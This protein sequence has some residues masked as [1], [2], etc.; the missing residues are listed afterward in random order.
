MQALCI[1][2][3]AQP[4]KSYRPKY[5]PPD[6]VNQTLFSEFLAAIG[7]DIPQAQKGLFPRAEQRDPPLF[8]AGDLSVLKSPA[9]CVIGARK[10]SEAGRK[11]ARR[12]ARVLVDAGVSVVSGLA[13]GIDT[14][15]HESA[16]ENGGRTA[17]VIGTPID[18][19]YPA[20]NAH[21]QET[22]WREQLLVSQFPTGHRTYPSDFPKRNRLMAAVTDGSIIVEAS[23][24]SGSLH[25][26]AECVRLGRWLFI[27]RSV[28]ED[29][30]LTWPQKFL[31]N[32]RV[33]VLSD[34]EDVLARVAA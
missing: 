26:A 4:L 10:V 7:R 31:G 9:I 6:A 23:D 18:R 24:S 8:W 13:R 34:P 5:E 12:I 28:V 32:D 3:M 15:A 27:M 33:V 11:R 20:E 16:L 25:Q 17:A 19:C 30:S 21:L 29:P 1:D 2:P 22:I 14:A